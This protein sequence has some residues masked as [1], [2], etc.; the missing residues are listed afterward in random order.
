MLSLTGWQLQVCPVAW[1]PS[2]GLT[3]L[4]LTA[5][6]LHMLPYWMLSQTWDIESKLDFSVKGMFGKQLQMQVPQRCSSTVVHV[7]AAT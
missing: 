3:G 4:V 7:G 5:C 2:N 1:L 6:L